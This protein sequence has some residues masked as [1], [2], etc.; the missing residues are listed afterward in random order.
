[1]SFRKS[2]FTGAS[3]LVIK[4]LPIAA[5]TAGLCVL[6]GKLL[7]TWLVKQLAE[8]E[9][10]SIPIKLMD[11]ADSRVN[12][13]QSVGEP[14]ATLGLSANYFNF[15]LLTGARSIKRRR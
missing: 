2:C 14:L 1:M 3:V 6:A 8:P 7:Q 15:L 9:R 5:A 12:R 11:L 13:L 4:Y 10:G